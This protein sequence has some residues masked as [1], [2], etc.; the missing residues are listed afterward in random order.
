MSGY[1]QATIGPAFE[2]AF[3]NTHWSSQQPEGRGRIVTF[4]GFLPANMHPDC[5]AAKAGS[6]VPPC[7][8]DAKVTFEWTFAPDGRVF[9]LSLV[10]PDAWPPAHRSTRE[11]MLYIFG[12]H[13]G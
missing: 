12:S 1:P 9:H 2:A 13:Q 6:S 3:S 7:V 8:Q 10:D 11:M 4:T 5:G